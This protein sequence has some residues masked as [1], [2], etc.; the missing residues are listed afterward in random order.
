MNKSF[1]K[2]KQDIDNL[3]ENGKHIA[4]ILHDVSKLVVPGVS[5]I[6]LTQFAE[7]EIRKVGGVPSFKGYGPR[8][9]PFPHALCVSVNDE[10]VHG[11][12]NTKRILREGDIVS[13]DI[14]MI[15]KGMFSDTAI[16]VPVGDVSP[17]ASKLIQITKSALD[18][19]IAAA[20]NTNRIG[21]I[22]AAVSKFANEAGYGIVRDLVG[23]GVGYAVH[24]D[25]MIPNIGKPGTGMKLMNGLVIAIEPMFNLGD[26]HVAFDEDDGWT[27]RTVDGSLSAHFEHTIVI[28]DNG[29]EVLT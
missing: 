27:V 6:K 23:H 28:T 5:T 18:A 8:E 26:Y 24:E 9:N 1:I 19:G 4:R 22:G 2:S 17:E 7:D 12:P 11:I 10:V 3:R 29:P 13:L 14:G 21:D 20:L 16:T 15:Y 25:P